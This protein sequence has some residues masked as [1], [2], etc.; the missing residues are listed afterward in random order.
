MENIATPR[1]AARSAHAPTTIDLLTRGGVAS[2]AYL[3]VERTIAR[4]RVILDH[5]N[6]VRRA[7][8]A[9]LRGLATRCGAHAEQLFVNHVHE[10]L[11]TLP[12]GITTCMPTWT[13]EYARVTAALLATYRQQ[14]ER[15]IALAV[16]VGRSRAS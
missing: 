16:D 5:D 15:R 11:T 13:S 2:P 9:A 7:P 14:A 8:I 10:V 6:L 4:A 3:D 1:V 12:G